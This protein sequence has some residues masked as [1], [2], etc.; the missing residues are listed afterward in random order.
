[1]TCIFQA[2]GALPAA[3]F[4]YIERPNDQK[5]W[6]AL[7]QQRMECITLL[8]PRQQGKT[9][10]INQLQVR[11]ETAGYLFVR[12]DLMP[13]S[14]AKS[15]AV[16]YSRIRQKIVRELNLEEGYPL[17][18]TVT[19]STSWYEFLNSLARDRF[20]AD[21]ENYATSRTKLRLIL[22][23]YFSDDE[24]H[25]LCFDLG[26]DYESLPARGK[27]GKAREIIAYLERR[28]EINKL[29]DQCSMLRPGVLAS[30]RPEVSGAS[31]YRLVI[32]F[33]EIGGVGKDWATGFFSAIRSV[34]QDQ[35]ERLSFILAGTI[36]PREL[37]INPEVSPFNV[38]T[39]IY[40]HDF[41]VADV[42]ALVQ[43]LVQSESTIH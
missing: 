12:V 11:C 8:E 25:T 29:I 34:W 37:I 28:D 41:S 30:P 27:A 18:Q 2:G 20:G 15:E 13:F 19:D 4:C 32:A 38:A 40:L 43:R 36:D 16:W 7:Q 9:S 14:G 23:R 42:E 35:R 24:L 31:R 39:P 33:D 17:L 10:F 26:I 21:R 3:S 22:S 5:A 1:M 6:D